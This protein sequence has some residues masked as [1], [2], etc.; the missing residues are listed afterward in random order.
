M[1]RKMLKTLSIVLG[2]MVATSAHAQ[3]PE[4]VAC[5]YGVVPYEPEPIYEPEPV[6]LYGIEEPVYPPA[7]TPGLVINGVVQQ[8]GTGTPLAGI[9]VSYGGMELISDA[10]GRFSFSLPVLDESDAELVFEATD[11]DG[12]DG[13]GKHKSAEVTVKVVDGVLSPMVAEQGLVIE[14]KPR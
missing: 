9:Q 1:R 4:D 13:G 12:K 5:E 8:A 11:I 2:S 3:S 7:P 10:D 14:L 6:P